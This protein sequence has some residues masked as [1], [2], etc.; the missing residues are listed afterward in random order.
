MALRNPSLRKDVRP[1][2]ISQ[3][4]EHSP[5]LLSLSL[6]QFPDETSEHPIDEVVDVRGEP[7]IV[8]ER[9]KRRVLGGTFR[10]LGVDLLTEELGKPGLLSVGDGFGYGDCHRFCWIR[11]GAVLLARSRRNTP[12]SARTA[13][14]LRY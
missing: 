9:C 5:N 4:V 7:L 11:A 2:S 13:L 8:R 14:L 12:C 1:L 10:V 3:R 6:A